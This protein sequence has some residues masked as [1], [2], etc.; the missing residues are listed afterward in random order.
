MR[1]AGKRRAMALLNTLS[2]F[3]TNIKN[4]LERHKLQ[5][6]LDAL[7]Q[8]QE[9]AI[10]LGNLIESSEG[11][12]FVT[13]SFL[14]EYCEV[15]FQIYDNLSR[16]RD[17]QAGDVPS[18][19]SGI[20]PNKI[21]KNL[22]KL[23]IK[24]ENSVKYDIKI[25]KEAVFL[26]YK[27]SMW[28]SLESVWQSAEADPDCDAYVIPI[29]YFD[30]NP[31]GSLGQAYY[32]KDQYPDYVPITEYD[33]FD[34]E[35]HHPDMIFIHNPY[36]YTNH[37]T[38]IHP[39]YYSENLKKHTDCLVYIPYYATAGGMSEAQASCPAYA[40][41]DYIVIQSKRHRKYFDMNIPDEKFLAFGSPK[42]DS[43]MH[44]CQ[45]P[46]EIPADWRDKVM[47]K[48]GRKKVYF[49]NTSIGGMLG[50]TE[51]F[52]KKMEY[53]FETFK[54]RED[55]CLIWR[56]HPL[57]ES[58]FD[59]M[60]KSFRPIYDDLKKRF[61]EENVGILDLTPDIE[62]TIALCDAYIGD[63]GTSVT[64]LFGVVGKPLFI[65]NNRIHTL[66]AEDDWRGEIFKGLYADGQNRWYVTQGNKLYYSKKDDYH[67]EYACDLSEYAAGGYYQRAVEFEGKVYICPGN[68]QDILEVEWKE[69]SA[70]GQAGKWMVKRI[71]LKRCLAQAGAFAAT[72]QVGT[73]L[74]ILP[75][76]Y[77]AIVRFDMRTQ[78]VRYLT[79]ANDF[80]VSD[81]RGGRRFGGVAAW[82]NA[83]WIGSPYGNQ[84]FK[85]EA[86]TLKTQV[87]DTGMEGG[88]LGIY[89]EE[90][91][92]WLYPYEGTTVACWKPDT[93]ET[94][95][96]D[97]HVE[98]FRCT[99]RPFGYECME[100]PFASPAVNED[101]IVFSPL[102]GNKFVCI[103]KKSGEAK[104]WESPVKT[105][106]WPKSGYYPLSGVGYFLRREHDSAFRYNDSIHRKVYE[107][108]TRAGDCKEV[109]IVFDVDELKRHE[110]GF[111]EHSQWMQYCCMENAFNSLKDFID[112]TITGNPFDKEKQLAAFAKINANV[113]GTCGEEVY[114]FVTKAMEK[115]Q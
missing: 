64:S 46:P 60:R 66:P 59:S 92:I 39:A 94:I 112:G 16:I 20:N 31:D 65:L 5:S 70:D 35:A 18:A 76:K 30:K 95:K 58:T 52:L 27:A 114:R 29:P 98:G 109:D 38:T 49:F 53:V 67:Y 1:K 10:E 13:I 3:H 54:R 41:A 85:I 80:Y 73:Y 48:D 107:M 36:D 77:P 71:E 90:K 69:T 37:V 4:N 42:F 56:P 44:K 7:M 24:A 62:S 32:E 115:M 2:N 19:S 22:N 99:Q 45:N 17:V 68:A 93:F 43:V 51:A 21:Y 86:D 106:A 89:P 75:N 11:E 63:S 87:L 101:Q 78:E 110:P 8:C 23:I 97:A 34:L 28:D 81:G 57:M 104:E 103:D 9:T 25:R 74:F 84:I 61:V 6:V 88:I 72:V 96:Y 111:A 79:G 55:A 100:R 14:E 105:K 113:D 108:D 50:N 26:P 12:G 15:V 47:G 102:W 33:K 40:N 83:L 82:G 91:E